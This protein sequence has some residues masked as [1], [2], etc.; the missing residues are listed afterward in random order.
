MENLHPYFFIF[1][2]RATAAVRCVEMGIEAAVIKAVVMAE[3]I[4]QA[5]LRVRA[6]LMDQAWVVER[7]ISELQIQQPPEERPDDPG[8]SASS[9]YRSALSC[10][11]AV[12]IEVYGKAMNPNLS[13]LV[14]P[15]LIPL[16]E[17]GEGN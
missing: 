12:D 17:P 7:K 9:L 6:F 3:S 2:A 10:G 14:I 11:M 4:A 1:E 15:S 13:G 16:D 5:E 8:E